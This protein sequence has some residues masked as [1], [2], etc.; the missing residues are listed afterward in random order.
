MSEATTQSSLFMKLA[1]VM[2][3]LTRI[4]KSGENSY[5]KYK[6]ATEGDVAD[7]LRERLAAK[8]I[9]FF[10]SMV[11]VE[12]TEISRN[13]KT[14]WRTK[15]TFEFTFADGESGETRTCLW[16]SE[17]FDEQDKGINKAATAAVKYF[18]LKTFMLSTGDLAEDTD[19][20]IEPHTGEIKGGNARPKAGSQRPA[21]T[22]NTAQRPA[23]PKAAPANDPLLQEGQAMG[24]NIS[25]LKRDEEE[26]PK[27]D[28]RRR[29]GAEAFVNYWQGKSV[30]TSDLIAALKI[31]RWSE[32]TAGRK[33]ADAAVNAYIAAKS[34]KKTA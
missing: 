9:A 2:G 10:A 20:G 32:W 21:P 3:D 26:L 4:P 14:T 27:D 8:N 18:L 28:L 33:A 24:A 13:N 17:A 22:G 30:T 34:E 11:A 5:F 19:S 1:A 7:A 25:P 16:E 31:N 12:Q 6:F 29:E 15:A 23:S